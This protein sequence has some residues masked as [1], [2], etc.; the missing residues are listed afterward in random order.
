MSNIKSRCT[1]NVIC[2]F[3]SNLLVIP[4]QQSPEIKSLIGTHSPRR[5]VKALSYK[6][7]CTD[8]ATNVHLAFQ[9]SFFIYNI[10][11]F[12]KSFL[13]INFFYLSLLNIILYFK[14]DGVKH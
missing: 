9:T 5:L 13:T 4:P 6:C 10:K 2:F 1:I 7:F 11:E 8:S 14:Q 3:I 12:F